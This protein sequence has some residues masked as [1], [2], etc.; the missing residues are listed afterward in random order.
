MSFDTS[1]SILATNTSSNILS[2]NISSNKVL[3]EKPTKNAK[4][5]RLANINISTTTNVSHNIV[6]QLKVI[7]KSYNNYI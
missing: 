7:L 4:E 1:S 3:L 5:K 2:S 6:L